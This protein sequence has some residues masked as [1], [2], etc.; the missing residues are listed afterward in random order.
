[1]TNILKNFINENIDLINQNSKESWEELY[2]K[3]NQYYLL[4]GK[5]TDTLLIA[6]IDPANV[7]GYI[8]VNY[9]NRGTIQN[10]KIPHTVIDIGDYAFCYCDKLANIQIP[11]STLKIG[12]CSFAYCRS[13]KDVVIENNMIDIDDYAF[14]YCDNLKKVIY[15][16]TKEEAFKCGLKKKKWRRGSPIE[17]NCL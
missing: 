4:T 2:K 17:K 14:Q 7:L 6:G 9:L 13:L 5:F 12:Y 11:K 8:P 10:Y 15:K 16:G 1:M 3:S